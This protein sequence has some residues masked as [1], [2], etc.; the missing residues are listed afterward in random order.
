MNHESKS[1]DM[2]YSYSHSHSYKLHSY[3]YILTNCLQIFLI[4]RSS[5]FGSPNVRNRCY[6]VGV[7]QDVASSRHLDVLCAWACHQCPTIHTHRASLTEC[8]L[9]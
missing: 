6:I 7:R 5:D 1:S 4:D 2:S 9:D 3:T 8:F